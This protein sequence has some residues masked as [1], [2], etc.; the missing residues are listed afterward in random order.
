MQEV[1][2]L[3]KEEKRDP[4][5][6]LNFDDAIQ[7]GPLCGG[8]VGTERRPY[9]FT[10]YLNRNGGQWRLA[11]HRCDIEDI[12]DGRLTEMTMYCCKTPN[13]G[14]MSNLNEGGC[15]CD[16]VRNPDFG[17]FVFPEAREKLAQRGI[18]TV[19]ETSTKQD[20]L[21]ALGPP[22]LSGG[23]TDGIPVWVKY[24]RDDCQV[25]FEF[26]KSRQI[27]MVTIM[28]KDWEPGK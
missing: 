3:I 25:H 18:T 15:K 19:S 14:Y 1:F 23:G 5:V 20:V 8:R 21:A 17:H 9:Q 16:Y 10:Y 28:E 6:V 24:H 22:D 2:R 13:C 27:S 11:L 4:D 7:I 26:K 12:A